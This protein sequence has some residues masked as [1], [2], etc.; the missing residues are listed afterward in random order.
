M[1]VFMW[2]SAKSSGAVCC[3]ARSV[4]WVFLNHRKINFLLG[5][6][7]YVSASDLNIFKLSHVRERD[8]PL[9]KNIYCVR[10]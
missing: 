3:T 2:S 10:T 4:F 7:A 9:C 6:P 5:F 1:A 8:F